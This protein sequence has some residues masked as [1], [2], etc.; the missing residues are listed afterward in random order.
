M[1]FKRAT[2]SDGA[3]A[4]LGP[5]LHSPVHRP[6]QLHSGSRAARAFVGCTSSAARRSTTRSGSGIDVDCFT[7][8]TRCTRFRYRRDLPSVRAAPVRALRSARAQAAR[9]EQRP[10]MRAALQVKV[11]WWPYAP[12]G[13]ARAPRAVPVLERTLALTAGSR[14]HQ[15]TGDRPGPSAARCWCAAECLEQR[16]REAAEERA[17]APVER[18]S[19]A[20]FR[21]WGAVRRAPSPVRRAR[22]PRRR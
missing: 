2:I 12:A 14:C 18:R 11:A 19:A 15:A 7:S 3:D 6:L 16:P 1:L 17:V 10:R 21:A 5:G 9:A 8:S 22:R 13:S 20:R 4:G